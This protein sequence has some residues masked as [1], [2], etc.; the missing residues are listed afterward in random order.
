MPNINGKH[1][2]KQ[3]LMALHLKYRRVRFYDPGICTYCGDFGDEWD[4]S[5][6][7]TEAYTLDLD[8]FR[9][10]GGEMLLVPSCAKCNRWLGS[11]PLHT[12]AD[13]K[14]YCATKWRELFRREF[15][16]PKWDKDE[17]EELGPML[18][19]Y[20]A[21]SAKTADWV[22]ERIAFCTMDLPELD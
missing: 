13:R 18:K 9:D 7:L 12:V 3:R 21:T 6:S 14:L 5:P 11:Q 22:R 20:I 1:A 10:S 2:R 16:M 17:L 19:T 8:R 15:A 4:H